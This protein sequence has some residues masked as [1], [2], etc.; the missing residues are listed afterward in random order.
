MKERTFVS[1]KQIVIAVLLYIA[2]VVLFTYIDT[3]NE[4]VSLYKQLDQQLESAAL[5]AP[6]LLPKTLHH[7]AMT[8]DDLSIEQD[9]VNRLKLSEYT[10][11]NDVIYIYTLILRDEKVYFTSSSAT[12]EERESDEVLS[13]YFDHYDDVDPR[14]FDV[15]KSKQ[16]SFLEYTDQWGTFRSV[17][18]P[19]YSE[20][21]TLYV[22]VADLSISHIETVLNR[23]I[24]RSLIF[25]V[26]F[27]LFIYPL[28]KV[29]TKRRQNLLQVLDAKVKQQ[30]VEL[31]KSENRL[32]RA[33]ISANQAWFEINVQTGLISVSDEFKIDGF[34]DDNAVFPIDSWLAKI[35]PDD[36]D[37]TKAMFES[38]MKSG[39]TVTMIYRVKSSQ[40]QW[41]WLQSTCEVVEWDKKNNPVVMVGTNI[42][43][44][45]KKQKEEVFLNRQ[46]QI[47]QNHKAL[48]SLGK[49]SFSSL[50][51]AFNK[52][53][54]RSAVQLNIARVSVWYFNE[55]NT[56]ITCKS[57]Y[58]NGT[59]S[60]DATTLMAE[61][62]PNYFRLLNVSGFISAANAM[63]HPATSDFA[64]TYLKPLGITSLLDTPIFIK[65]KMIGIVCSEQIGLMRKWTVE[66]EEFARTIADLCAQEILEF[67]RKQAETAL[68]DYK[69]DLENLV[70]ER[71]A[72]MKK[73]RDEAEQANMAKSNFLSSMSHELRT[74][75]NSILG[76]SQLLELDSKQPLTQE[77]LESVK[78]IKDSG[79]HLLVLI[80]DVLD[81]AKI[82]SGNLDVKIEE[83]DVATLVDEMV[84][85]VKSEAEK[86]SVSLEN[87]ID[88][89]AITTLKAD[90]IKLK[91]VLLNFASNGI[92]YNTENGVV[93]FSSTITDHGTIRI[94]VS[95]TGIGVEKE[96]FTALF[97]PFNRLGMANSSLPG[98]G[99]GLTIC[100]QLV[101]LMNGE[102]GVLQNSDG[103]GLTFWVE[104]EAIAHS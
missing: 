74:P 1:R 42:D 100:K 88:K 55:E 3:N 32:K 45:E 93:R 58:F 28:Y 6:I 11:N 5:T 24:Y 29:A 52:I 62:Y 64:D 53:A 98:T 25:A 79:E 31:F 4:K 60:N 71:T 21:G 19:L 8:P 35:H 92:K 47:L 80:N 16:K 85:L 61:D 104:F 69:Q 94:N 37:A 103:K 96:S 59:V 14:V 77:Q 18:I 63:T 17:F 57:L 10:D 13:D 81:L 86:S 87:N 56:M 40:G 68:N 67:E 20:D 46:H 39:E 44:T 101:E 102:I 91:Q 97:E 89:N 51:E 36:L 78:Y 9:T 70:E 83:V 75:M 12:I 43:I 38:G 99:I 48:L 26:L 7:K 49:E 33:L 72:E 34:G 66:D 27:L 65:G 90:Y 23:Q 50:R 54:T 95:D 22:T 15:F 84:T 76:F 82:E 30:T 73:A 41:A 2:W